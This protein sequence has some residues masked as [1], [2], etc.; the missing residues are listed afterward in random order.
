MLFRGQRC[1]NNVC[2]IPNPYCQTLA[3]KSRG[4]HFEPFRGGTGHYANF[5][6]F[7][8]EKAFSLSHPHSSVFYSYTSVHRKIF[9]VFCLSW[10]RRTFLAIFMTP[11]QFFLRHKKILMQHCYTRIS[12][13]FLCIIPIMEIAK[14]LSLSPLRPKTASLRVFLQC[15]LEPE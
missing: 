12:C 1:K 4:C 14:V 3:S 10:R 15:Q 9:F 8:S 2:W 13:Y 11:A 6:F 7:S 5:S